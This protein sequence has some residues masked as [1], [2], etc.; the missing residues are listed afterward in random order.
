MLVGRHST[1]SWH[2]SRNGTIRVALTRRS[3][4]KRLMR[5]IMISRRRVS[6][7]DTNCR[8]DGRAVRHAH[9]RTSRS[10]ATVAIP[11]A[12]MCTIIAIGSICPVKMTTYT[13]I[14]QSIAVQAWSKLSL[15][16]HTP[17]GAVFNCEAVKPISFF[18][19]S[20]PS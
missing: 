6:V 9:L 3:L 15:D 17:E 8:R 1:V 20:Q 13:G 2:F 18:W 12:L 19:I 11:F 16:H 14:V 10:R 5:S 7:L 4:A